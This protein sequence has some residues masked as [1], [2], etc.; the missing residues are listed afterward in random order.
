[1]QL[2]AQRRIRIYGIHFDVDK[3]TI[4][5]K[6]DKVVAQIAKLLH[7][8]PS[9]RFRIE[10]HTDSDGGYEHNVILSEYRAQAVVN[11]LVT[12]YHIARS[13]LVAQGYGYS[14][15]VAPNTTMSYGRSA[16]GQLLGEPQRLVGSDAGA[17]AELPPMK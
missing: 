13:R 12:R 4:A 3:A 2:K 15:P 16:I 5:P 14:V 1:M 9:W 11:D 8:N 10:G 6:S 17:G 7:D